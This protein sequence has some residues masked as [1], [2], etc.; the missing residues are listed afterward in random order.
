MY[1]LQSLWTMAREK[2]DVT[3]VIL[4]NRKYAILL[5]ELA[6]VGANPG[7]TAL[8]MLDIGNPDLNW[9]QL[10]NGMGWRLR[11][12]RIWSGLL[13]CLVW[14]MVGGGRLLLSW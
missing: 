6:G 8:D 4:A 10:A 13:S 9:V 3:V 1:T 5:G 2:L 11:G 14:L 12:L 7:K